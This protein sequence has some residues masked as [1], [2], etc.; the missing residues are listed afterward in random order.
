MMKTEINADEIVSLLHDMG[1]R[2]SYEI[3]DSDVEVASA[4]QGFIWEVTI[5][6][7][8]ESQASDFLIFS[9][10]RG[11]NPVLF[12]IGRICN[13]FNSESPHGVATYLLV[14]DPDL[15]EKAIIKLEFSVSLRG[16]V[17]EDW[18]SS[19]ITGWD[20]ILGMFDKKVR[21]CEEA[22]SKEDP[23]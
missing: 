4:S 5:C 22:C 6:D 23:F 19:Q 9:H 10:L 1:Y 15:P 20:F 18:V 3:N 14:D 8:D 7:S 2:A 21:E 12:P 16:G 17:S 13:E 11:V